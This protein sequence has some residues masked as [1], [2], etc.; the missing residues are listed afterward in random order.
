MSVLTYVRPE[1]EA[2]FPFHL[3]LRAAL[4]DGYAT[5]VEVPAKH[6]YLKCFALSGEVK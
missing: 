2:N 3:E 6:I 1:C 4:A 5:R